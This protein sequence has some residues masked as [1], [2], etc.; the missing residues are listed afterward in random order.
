M[1]GNS[2]F[3][4][5][6]KPAKGDAMFKLRSPLKIERDPHGGW[7]LILWVGEPFDYT[8]PF[9]AMLADIADLLGQHPRNDLSLPTFAEG[10]DFV[11]GTL[12]FGDAPLRIYY[13]HSLGYLTLTSDNEATLKGVAARVQSKIVIG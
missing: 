6:G 8:T 3:L 10:E 4:R 1:C 9:R 7:N 5:N 11:E 2:Q 12:Q 13:E